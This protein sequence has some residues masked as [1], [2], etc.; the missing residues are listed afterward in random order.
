VSPISP[1]VAYER[2]SLLLMWI[3]KIRW[4]MES[5]NDEE[6]DTDNTAAIQ[7]VASSG[8]VVSVCCVEHRPC[9]RATL[10][11]GAPWAISQPYLQ[12]ASSRNTRQTS[13]GLVCFLR[14]A[15]KARLVTASNFLVRAT[16]QRTPCSSQYL[17]R[18]MMR[19]GSARQHLDTLADAAWP[20]TSSHAA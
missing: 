7:H 5:G 2:E 4:C 15:T 10:R 9:A 18:I 6:Q 14:V 16:A 1:A 12:H 19:D 17:L 13:Y 20:L 11:R 8:R 3:A